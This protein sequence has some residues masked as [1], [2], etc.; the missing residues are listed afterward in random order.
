M[1]V[2]YN[3]KQTSSPIHEITYGGIFKLIP[4]RSVLGVKRPELAA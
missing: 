2:R 4:V 3:F 1:F